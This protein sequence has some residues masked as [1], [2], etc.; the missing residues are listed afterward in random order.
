M[1]TARRSVKRESRGATRHRSKSLSGLS[2]I[3]PAAALASLTRAG[4]ASYGRHHQRQAPARRRNCPT[5][6]EMIAAT[7]VSRTVVREAVAALRA[8]G[9]VMTPSGRRRLRRGQ[10]APA[11]PH[12][13]A[14]ALSSL[15]EVLEVMELAHR[16]RNRGRRACRGPRFAGADRR[17]SRNAWRPS[18]RDQARRATRSTR[19]SRSIA[20]DRGRDRQSAVPRVSW[21]ISAASSSRVRRSG[22]GPGFRSRT[23]QRNLPEGASRHR[24]GDPRGRGG[25]KRATAMRRHL[26]NS[27]KRYQSLADKLGNA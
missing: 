4:D 27:R 13:R 26:L 25:R 14:T 9:L 8:E 20:R 24:A 3:A 21:N 6:Q 15:R 22:G 7:G 10:R 16:D 17:R 23:L 5:E 12:R 1:M 18:T 11:V 19:I 2:A